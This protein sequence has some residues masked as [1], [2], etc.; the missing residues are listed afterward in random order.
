MRPDVATADT[1]MTMALPD[2]C[3]A[4]QLVFAAFR[5]ARCPVDTAISN[6]PARP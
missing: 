5:D 2:V 3:V 6:A 4:H 1:S